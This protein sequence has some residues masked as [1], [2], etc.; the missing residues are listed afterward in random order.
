[1]REKRR[2]RQLQ[3]AAFELF[4]DKRQP[5]PITSMTGRHQIVRPWRLCK[6]VRAGEEPKL[7]VSR[8]QN[9]NNNLIDDEPRLTFIPRF[10]TE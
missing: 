6:S 9:R 4:L 8:A 3:S 10:A 1:M 7:G 2:D 5:V